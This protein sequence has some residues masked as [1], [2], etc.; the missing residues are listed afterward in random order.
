M[1]KRKNI[2]HSLQKYLPDVYIDYIVS[3]M[4]SENLQ[5]KITKPRK[6]K[7]GD[8]RHPYN[9]KPH[10]I[11]INS[12]LNPYAFLITTIHEF[13]HMNT[14]I[15]YGNKVKAHGKE[16]KDEFKKLLTP[17]LQQKELPL[18]I[19]MALWRSLHNL[20]ASSC[21]DTAL[22]RALKKYDK[23]PET[24][25]LLEE[26]PN[27]STFRLG[28]KTFI[29]EKLRRSRYLCTEVHTRK[30]YLVSRLAEVEPINSTNNGE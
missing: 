27:L 4:F 18:E 13:A 3:L 7:Q 5:F 11:S 22:F 21:T 23:T 28:K 30:H 15:Q 9:G 8:Y 20:K 26:L 24:T 6:T 17:V 10:R 2:T 29:R 25:V 14:Y 1:N 12:N 16:W 19:E